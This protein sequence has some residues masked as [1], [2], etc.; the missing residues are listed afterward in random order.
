MGVP[1]SRISFWGS[2][3]DG[4]R[5]SLVAEGRSRSFAD[6]AALCREGEP[7]THVFILLA[8]WV[9]VVSATADGREALVALRGEGEVV[10]EIAGAVTGYR[11]A[12]VRAIGPVRSLIIGVE[13]FTAILDAHPGAANAYRRAITDRQYIAFELQLSY[14]LTSGAQRLARLLLDLAERHGEATP[15]GVRTV[16]PLSQEEL[17]SL[18]GA[19]R[20]TVTRTL[21]DWRAR[22]VIST[23]HRHVT[24]L[25]QAALWRISG[26]PAPHRD[27]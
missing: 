5:R 6:G 8:G 9:K 14:A 13:R 4:E 18:I 23:Q 20:A 24:I 21:G 15:Q 22:H 19:S 1:P 2:L 7:T 3:N 11:T 26:R 17:A 25:D 27:P 10:G 12:T 16:L